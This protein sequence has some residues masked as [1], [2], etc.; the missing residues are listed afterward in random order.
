MPI[1]GAKNAE[2]AEEFSGALGWRLTDDD[3]NEL[4]SMALEIK[5]VIGFPVERL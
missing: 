5:P 4:R 1:P 2:Q 3:I